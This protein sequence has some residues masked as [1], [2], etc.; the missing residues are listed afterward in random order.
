MIDHVTP[1]KPAPGREQG[2]SAYI[3]PGSRPTP[4]NKSV[5]WRPTGTRREGWRGVE[6]QVHGVNFAARSRRPR[7]RGVIGAITGRSDFEREW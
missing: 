2:A 4:W 3:S 6:H 7:D 1:A 5:G